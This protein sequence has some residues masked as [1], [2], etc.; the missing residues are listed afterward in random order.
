[1]EYLLGLAAVT[2]FGLVLPILYL[3]VELR[4]RQVAEET[5]DVDRV[6]PT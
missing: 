6:A 4:Q 5:G 2:V 3:R 1:M